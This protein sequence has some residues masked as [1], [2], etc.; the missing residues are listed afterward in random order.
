MERRSEPHKLRRKLEEPSRT[1]G[2]RSQRKRRK[3]PNITE[4][5]TFLGYEIIRCM[6]SQG[7]MVP[8][9][10]VPDK[11]IKRFQHTVR[12]ITAPGTHNDSV[13]AKIKALN[14]LIR[15][16]CQYY[17]CTSGPSTPFDRLRYEV[18]EGMAHW[19]GRKFEI[20]KKQAIIRYGRRVDN[21][22]STQS[23]TLLM[24]STG[25]FPRKKLLTRKWHNPYIAKEAIVR[26]KVFWYERLWSGHGCDRAIPHE[27]R[28]LLPGLRNLRPLLLSHRHGLRSPVPL[29]DVLPNATKPDHPPVQDDVS[30]C[31]GP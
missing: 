3:S 11:A 16:W 22:F 26:E 30:A 24:P 5:F 9:V 28:S 12:R 21:T 15:G 8:K 18:Y 17:R 1:W 19:L 27:L 13:N 29:M 10:W 6:G 14:D 2:L 7:K 4:G 20:S 25:T 31:D 23:I